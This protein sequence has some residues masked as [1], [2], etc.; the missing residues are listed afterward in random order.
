MAKHCRFEGEIRWDTTKPDGQPRRCLDTSK[1]KDAMGWTAQVSF[2]EG[3][4]RTIAWFEANRNDVR[5][6]VYG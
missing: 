1:A 5:E 2:E 6:V 4:Q 3:L